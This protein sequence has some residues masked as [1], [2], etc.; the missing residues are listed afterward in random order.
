VLAATIAVDVRLADGQPTVRAL[1]VR[2]LD[3][4]LVFSVR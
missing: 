1:L 4:F 2:R 3:R